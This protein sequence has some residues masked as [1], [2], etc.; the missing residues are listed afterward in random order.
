MFKENGKVRTFLREK[1]N[2]R[3]KGYM[4]T[5]FEADGLG[6]F[7]KNVGFLED[8]KFQAAWKNAEKLNY[9]GWQKSGLGVPDI[10]WRA[11]VCCWAAKNALHLKG[12]F[13]ECGV[14]T[15]LLSLTVSEYIDLDQTGKNFWLFDTFEGIPT[16]DLDDDEKK[17]ADY[18]N[19]LIYFD[20]YE[21]A[22]RNF[23]TYKNAHLVR[24]VIP[25]TLTIPNIED[26]SFLSID[27]NNAMAEKSAIENLWPK[28]SHG[29]I[30]VIDD[31]A[32]SGHESQY[33]MWNEFAARVDQIILTLP[34][35]Q[36]LL[37][38]NKK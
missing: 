8:E 15:G 20:V 13:V 16:A 21:L 17:L 4:R 12:D 7:R 5:S 1:R 38:A 11:H 32:W 28:L 27:L 33:Q 22:K 9:E 10:R 23:A 37:I 25:E 35:G 24:G 34:T 6:T 30:V 14:H 29:A 36:G 18:A 3:K 19:E 2:A 31:Y 26:I